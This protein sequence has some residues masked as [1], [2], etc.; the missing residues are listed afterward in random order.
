MF[1]ATFTALLGTAFKNN[2]YNN[3]LPKIYLVHVN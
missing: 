1:K 2:K 3:D